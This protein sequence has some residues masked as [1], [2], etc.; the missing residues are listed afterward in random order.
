MSKDSPICWLTY[1]QLIDFQGPYM[2]IWSPLPVRASWFSSFSITSQW[3]DFER[4]TIPLIHNRSLCVFQSCVVL[5][6]S[7]WAMHNFRSVISLNQTL[8]RFLKYRLTF[9]SAATIITVVQQVAAVRRWIFRIVI[10]NVSFWIQWNPC[11]DEIFREL[12]DTAQVNWKIYI[13]GFDRH[14]ICFKQNKWFHRAQKFMSILTSPNMHLHTAPTC[15]T[16]MMKLTALSKVKR[17]FEIRQPTR[18]RFGYITLGATWMSQARN[19]C[20]I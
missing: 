13:T 18:E 15:Y 12:P 11:K 6:G 3:G 10:I 19:N 20:N 16:T 9:D 14:L 4:S 8:P 5:R 2:N 7:Y 1:C 17:H